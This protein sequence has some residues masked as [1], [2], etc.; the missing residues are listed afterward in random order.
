MQDRDS[1]PLRN[2]KLY[3]DQPDHALLLSWHIASESSKPSLGKGLPGNL[4]VHYPEPQESTLTPRVS[5]SPRGENRMPYYLPEAVRKSSSRT[6]RLKRLRGCQIQDGVSD[7]WHHRFAEVTTF[8]YAYPAS[9]TEGSATQPRIST[10]LQR[11]E[12]VR[13]NR[14]PTNPSRRALERSEICQSGRIWL[15]RSLRNLGHARPRWGSFLLVDFDEFDLL[16]L[17]CCELV[18]PFAPS[19]FFSRHGP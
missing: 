14:P 18:P 15:L 4:H 17:L 6:K 16:R 19:R 12:I 10:T 2:P 3:D 11:Q 9:P 1:S 13:F 5:L 7:D 8:R